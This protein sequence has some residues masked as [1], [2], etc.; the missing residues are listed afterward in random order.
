MNSKTLCAITATGILSFAGIVVETAMNVAFPTLMHDF[1][2]STSMVQWLTTG[3][4]LILALVV[5]TS[6]FLKRNYPTKKLFITSNLLFIAGTIAAMIAP[7]FQIILLG[8]LIQGIGT[9]IALPLMF[10]IIVEQVPLTKTGTVMGFANLIIAIAPAVGPTF[11]GFIVKT[12]GWRMIFLTLLPLLI[13]S[14][15]LGITSIV[16][17]S[18]LEKLKFDLGDWITLLISFS[19]LIFATNQAALSGWTNVKVMILLFTSFISLFVFY[20]V[21]KKQSQP[22]IRI[23]V[24][25]N[26]RFDLSMVALM[27]SQFSILSTSFLLPN[28]AQLTLHQN[29]FVAGL[30]LLP[31]ATL[32]VFLTLLGGKAYDLWGARRPIMIGFALYAIATL[33]FGVLMPQMT[34]WMIIMI[35]AVAIIG[36]AFSSGNTLTN[37]LHQVED[38]FRTD[39]NAI[40]NTVQQLSGALGTSIV[41]TIVADQQRLASQ[42]TLGTMNGVRLSFGIL[43]ILQFIAIFLTWFT[44]NKK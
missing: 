3:Y 37:G 7:S 10:N 44:T 22:L 18:K 40:L 30:L 36:Q 15:I 29:A 23:K 13:I 38:E 42:I 9:G 11:G 1:H 39:A 6:S 21:S 41:A 16:Q 43:C 27:I 32:G 4:L 19:S 8:R 28:F 17:G 2:V 5:P 33:M 34:S 20:I 25:K 24:F 12:F 14:L 26:W 31:G 35:F